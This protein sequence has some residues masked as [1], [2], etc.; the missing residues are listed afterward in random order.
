[1]CE[2]R[3][4]RGKKRVVV[5]GRGMSP[6]NVTHTRGVGVG[7]KSEN[8]IR[9]TMVSSNMGP[10]RGSGPTIGRWCTPCIHVGVHTWY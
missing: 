10:V 6:V 5:S 4:A 1:M 8:I 3:T 2:A 9:E 7:E